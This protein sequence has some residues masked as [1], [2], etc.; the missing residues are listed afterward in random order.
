MQGVHQ[1]KA[2][3]S[4]NTDGTEAHT[5]LDANGD[6][7]A[8][9]SDR[10][11]AVTP[12]SGDSGDTRSVILEGHAKVQCTDTNVSVGDKLVADGSG[13]GTVVKA[14]ATGGDYVVG[15]A[16]EACTDSGQTIEIHFSP[17][18]NAT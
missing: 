13:N 15:F 16:K 12:D 3:K 18:Y 4:L 17:A 5:L 1:V 6:N 11:V 10:S 9:A 7:P 2:D 8:S 14:S